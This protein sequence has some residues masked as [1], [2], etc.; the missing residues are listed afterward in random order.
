MEIKICGSVSPYPKGECSCPSFLITENDSRIL[1]DSGPGSTRNIEMLSELKN[2]IVFISHYHPD[3]Y[4]DLTSLMYS[5]FT[6]HNLGY[7]ADK[8]GVYLPDEKCIEH[9]YL[10][11]QT[12]EH[13]ADYLEYNDSSIIKHGNMQVTFARN[14]HP[15]DTYAIRVD[16]ED[17][18]VV[19]SS[20]TGFSNN[21]IVSLANGAD[22]LICEASYLKGFERKNDTHLFA[23][24]AAIIASSA[25]VDK[26]YLF[27]TYPEID[28]EE[29]LKEA[30]EIFPS[31]YICEDGKKLNLVRK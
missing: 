2:L 17:G 19:Y 26:L 18:S 9:D 3:H 20:D 10:A 16:G 6:N 21:K 11:D 1:L 23:H 31:T 12:R 4:S 5:S 22:I 14:P 24:E 15:R 8:V 13:Y 25:K 7:L 29:Y 27:H 28:K 30:R